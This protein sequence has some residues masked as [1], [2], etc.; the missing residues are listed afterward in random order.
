M[1]HA[2]KVASTWAESRNVQAVSKPKPK[3]QR[4]TQTAIHE[5]RNFPV[6]KSRNLKIFRQQTTKLQGK[7]R[8]NQLKKPA[9]FPVYETFFKL[10]S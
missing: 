8:K 7:T 1:S 9:N 4:K 6:A 2:Q 10:E 3:K 5:S